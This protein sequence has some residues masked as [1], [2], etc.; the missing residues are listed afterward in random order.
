MPVY[1]M[2][3]SISTYPY[4]YKIYKILVLVVLSDRAE[5]DMM[6]DNSSLGLDDS[7]NWMSGISAPSPGTS[8]HFSSASPR[9]GFMRG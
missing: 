4:L 8:P 2:A 5:A 3:L 9:G 1:L 7:T 6:E